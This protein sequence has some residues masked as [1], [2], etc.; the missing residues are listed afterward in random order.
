MENKE[1]GGSAFPGTIPQFSYQ[2][3]ASGMTLRDWFAGQALAGIM[4]SLANN[5]SMTWEDGARGCY[6]AADAMIAERNKP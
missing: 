4:E 2:H 6:M 1:T 5:N 3:P